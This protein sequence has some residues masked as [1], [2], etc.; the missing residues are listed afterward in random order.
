MMQVYYNVLL[1]VFLPLQIS[2]SA[3]PEA[4]GSCLRQNA[5]LLQD[6]LHTNRHLSHG[7]HFNFTKTHKMHTHRAQKM[8]DSL[9][10][11]LQIGLLWK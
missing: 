5:S 10:S 4:P 6:G 9:T 1:S 2:T 7:E 3:A 11:Y 8:S